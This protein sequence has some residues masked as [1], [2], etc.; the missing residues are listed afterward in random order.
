MYGFVKADRVLYVLNVLTPMIVLWFVANFVRCR[1]APCVGV[2]FA[3]RPQNTRSVVGGRPSLN[4]LK[5]S[6]SSFLEC[7]GDLASSQG[8]RSIPRW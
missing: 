1:W 5:T 7:R 4:A 8:R 3:K 2:E 6:E